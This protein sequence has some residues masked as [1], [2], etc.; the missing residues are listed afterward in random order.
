MVSIESRQSER[1]GHSVHTAILR[2]ADKL[3]G[4]VGIRRFPMNN[5]IITSPDVAQELLQYEGYGIISKKTAL[6][7]RLGEEIGP[8]SIV[9]IESY[10]NPQ[11]ITATRELMSEF[12]REHTHAYISGVS[13]T[14]EKLC[15]EIKN[16]NGMNDLYTHIHRAYIYGL[17]QAFETTDDVNIDTLQKEIIHISADV[18][19]KTAIGSRAGEFFI[20][21]VLGS[22]EMRRSESN[23]WINSVIDRNKGL[24]DLEER[25]DSEDSMRANLL[26]LLGAGTTSPAAVACWSIYDIARDAKEREHFIHS[27]HK[28]DLTE[29]MARTMV[30]HPFGFVINRYVDKDITIR[31]VPLYTGDTVWFLTIPGKEVPEQMNMFGNSFGSGPRDCLGKHTAIGAYV[32]FMQV[33][34]GYFTNWVVTEPQTPIYFAT[35]K[36][37]GMNITITS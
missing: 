7:R 5:V 27:E 2:T 29:L 21:S 8:K 31:D 14:A 20:S 18:S 36:P 37:K 1:K 35:L 3:T 16:S 26:L 23:K 10:A 19:I 22:R 9:S 11:E 12:F 25:K 15:E 24:W 6:N 4:E 17:L 28:R 33:W 34:Q 30:R 32:K 13:Q